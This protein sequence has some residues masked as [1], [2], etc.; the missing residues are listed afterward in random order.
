MPLYQTKTIDSILEPVA[1][2]VRKVWWVIIVA[3]VC[4]V[5]KLIIFHEG[6]GNAMPD[7]D[8]PVIAVSK[9]VA[10]LIDFTSNNSQNMKMKSK[11]EK[12]SDSLA[13]ASC[14]LKYL[15]SDKEVFR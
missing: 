13:Q 6:D 1:P 2:Q 15:F 12:A 7:L 5:C 4:Q 14:S 3:V 9:A 8:V 11:M 10:N